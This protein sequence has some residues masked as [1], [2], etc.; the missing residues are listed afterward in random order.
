MATRKRRRTHTRTAATQ[1]MGNSIAGSAQK[2]WL[3]GLGAFERARAEGPK[4]FD[5]L[6]EQGLALGGKARMAGEDAL[7]GM[8]DRM[9]PPPARKAPARASATRGKAKRSA[10]GTAA[11]RR[12]K[13]RPSA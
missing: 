3:A 13:A 9:A 2:I 4:M 11:K 7:R 10:A 5:L 8:L 1:D 12:K 6:V